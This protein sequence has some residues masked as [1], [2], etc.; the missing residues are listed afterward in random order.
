MILE[1]EQNL[2]LMSIV[3]QLLDKDDDIS[4]MN[5]FVQEYLQGLV[6]EIN[7]MEE[8]EQDVIYFY[9]DSFFNNLNGNKRE[10]H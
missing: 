5:P 8:A 2:V 10:L 6:E 4:D 7:E 9:A 1:K 3:Y